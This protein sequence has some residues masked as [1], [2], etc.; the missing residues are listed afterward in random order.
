M[1][2]KD[3]CQ[4]RIDSNDPQN[5]AGEILVKGEQVMMG[6]YK[7]EKDT[8][9]VLDKDGWL[10]TGDMGT[11]DEDGTLNIRGRC[12]TMILTDNGQNIYP[13]EIEDKLNNMPLV[14]ESLVLENDGKLYGLV[15]PDFETCEREGIDRATLEATM[16]ENLKT[17]NTQIAAYERLVSIS[18]Y[19][20]EFE[21]TPKKSIKRYLYNASKLGI[22]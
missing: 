1:Y 3:Y 16:E 14:L 17:L 18:I 11:L 10:H 2:L 8:K 13:E 19:P 12:K 15:V 9:A 5:V 6:Y 22:K 7:N 20:S 4:V 21:K